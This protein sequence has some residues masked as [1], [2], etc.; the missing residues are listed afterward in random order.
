M[1]LKVY[2]TLTRRKEPFRVSPDRQVRMF[3]CGPTVYDYVHL[4]HARTYLAFDTITRYLKFLGYK[5]QYLMNITDVAER[6]V[7][8]AEQLK[9]AP[10]DL[11]REYENAFL[12][13]MQSLGVTQVDRFER[14]SEAIP[15]MIAQVTGLI[16]RGI[17]YETETGVYFEV[18]KFP[19]FGQLSGQSH[20]ELGLRRLELCSSK[21]NP[22]DFSLWRKY[23]KGLAWDSPWGRGRPG[24]HIEDT[25][26]SMAQFGDT[27]DIHG[28]ASELIF[29]HHEAE[30]AQAEALTGKIPF[31][32]YWIH[33][34]LLNVDGRKM[35]KSLGN[36][37]RIRDALH[38]YSAAE[39][40]FYFASVHYREPMIF[41]KNGLTNAIRGLNH[42]RK[43]FNSF[44][45]AQPATD[46]RD[47]KSS[48]N[49]TRYESAFKRHMNNDFYTPGALDVLQEFADKLAKVSPRF[50]Q[51]TKEGLEATF[52]SMASV[53]GIL[54]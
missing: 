7:Q 54:S 21:R 24:W 43:N 20:E 46:S 32:R 18:D 35:S 26:I 47:R 6:V 31:V 36:M 3:V 2:N 30:I 44:L 51:Q 42:L 4:G 9:R 33:T 11:A 40:R 25:A 19:K 52:R 12:E 53:L 28:G 10:L 13:D 37:I 50:S 8:R 22:E 14:A 45:D 23:E 38:E 27:Y 41:S 34:G 48:A 5:I 15:K 16:D 49:W 1:Q 29:P 17:G 39:L